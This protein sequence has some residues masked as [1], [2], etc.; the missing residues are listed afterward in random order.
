MSK[1]LV[2]FLC[3]LTTLTFCNIKF[4]QAVRILAYG[5]VEPK[6]EAIASFLLMIA[7]AISWTIYFSLF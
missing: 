4:S 7:V 2:L 1:A 6:K 5:E 3:L